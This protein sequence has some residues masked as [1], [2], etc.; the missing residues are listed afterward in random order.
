M[1]F[2]K[3]TMKRVK[4]QIYLSFSEREAMLAGNG[5]MIF[6]NQHRVYSD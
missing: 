1:C 4:N 2:C 6:T 5:K 3:D